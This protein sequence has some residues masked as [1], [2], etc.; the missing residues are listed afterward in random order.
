MS[1]FS[2]IMKNQ[3]LLN[4]QWFTKVYRTGVNS[5]CYRDIPTDSNTKGRIS[6]PLTPGFSDSLSECVSPS[7]SRFRF[8]YKDHSVLLN[9]VLPV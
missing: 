6:T 5:E 3:R 2:I 8:G 4:V 7:Q 9:E 1:I